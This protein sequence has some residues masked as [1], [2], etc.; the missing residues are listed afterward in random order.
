[1]LILSQLP[2][3]TYIWNYITIIYSASLWQKLLCSIFFIFCPGYSYER[4]DGSVRGEERNLAVKNFSSQDIFVFLLSTKAGNWNT[5]VC[6]GRQMVSL[7]GAWL[8]S[9]FVRNIHIVFVNVSWTQNM[10]I[11]FFFLNQH[12]LLLVFCTELTPVLSFCA[13]YVKSN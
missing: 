1:M 10:Q 7:L 11:S 6:T 2:I 4:L 12:L 13:E 8:N 9:T 5:K 3:Q